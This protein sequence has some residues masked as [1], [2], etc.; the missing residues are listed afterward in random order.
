VELLIS[1]YPGL[2]QDDENQP[3]KF[4]LKVIMPQEYSPKMYLVTLNKYIRRHL[5]LSLEWIN[6]EGQ[7]SS[8][9]KLNKLRWLLLGMEEATHSQ[10]IC[11]A[12]YIH[13]PSSMLKKV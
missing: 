5:I 13:V 12:S 8:Y 11:L 6:I 7:I 4:D 1:F 3:P 10:L 2:T 9:T